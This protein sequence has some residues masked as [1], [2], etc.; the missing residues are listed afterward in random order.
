MMKLKSPILPFA[1]AA[2]ATTLAT[3]AALVLMS[4][5]GTAGAQT[6]NPQQDRIS[7]E[8]IHADHKTYEATQARIKALNDGGR[9]VADYHLS[10]AQCWL[11]VS[12]HEYTRNDR[13]AFPQEALDESAKLIKL[14]EAKASPLP[15]DTPLVNNA[16]RLRPD[17][18]AKALKLQ[19]HAGFQCVQQR[20]ACGEVELVHAGNESRQQGWRHA[21]PYVQ[22]AEDQINAAEME[23][24][25]CAP[26]PGAAVPVPPVAPVV[27]VAVEPAKPA[28]LLANLLFQ[29]DQFAKNKILPASLAQLD[30]T[31]AKVKRE[32]IQ[33]T[34]VKLTGFADRT[35]KPAYNAALAEKRSATVRSYLIAQGIP[36]SILRVDSKGDAQQIEPCR[37]G[38]KALAEELACL[39]PNRRVEVDFS[40]AGK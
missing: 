13:S 7:D 33:L 12:F 2:A 27:P 39:T 22:I 23:A 20:V 10:K 5:S 19:S 36:S 38:F 3:L 28:H 11:D 8:A 29:H 25:A 30:E 17:L 21:K 18:W 24:D 6:L 15:M 32:G 26:K 9:R 1:G 40:W 4:H 31:L 16:E 34:E 35:G 37:A 14:M